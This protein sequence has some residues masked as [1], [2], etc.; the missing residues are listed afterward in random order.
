MLKGTTQT[1]LFHGGNYVSAQDVQ[2]KDVFPVVFPFEK[3]EVQGPRENKESNKKCL[4][5]STLCKQVQIQSPGASSLEYQS[6]IQILLQGL[7]GWNPETKTGKKGIFGTP[8]AWGCTDEEQGHKT[9][10][11]HWSIWIEDFDSIRS[12]L[13]N[14]HENVRKQLLHE[15]QKYIDKI[16]CTSYG[17]ATIEHTCNSKTMHTTPAKVLSNPI[18][19]L[20]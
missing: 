4:A 18:S 2:I 8:M 1:L 16:M 10:H 19:Q 3:G 6:M 5:G 14:K 12:L 11:S 20:L 9:L 7:I 15:I 17:N 13:Y